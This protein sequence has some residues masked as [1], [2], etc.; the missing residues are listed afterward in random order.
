MAPTLHL[1]APTLA[2]ADD[3]LAF[4]LQNRTFFEASINART[5]GYYSADGM[6]AAITDAID[7]ARADT[8]FQFLVRDDAGTLVARVNLSRVRRAHFHCAEVGYRVAQT[9]SGRGVATQAVGQLVALAFSDL[10]LLRLEAT[11]RPENAASIQVLERNGFER[12]GVARRSFQLHGIW[13]DLI[14]FERHANAESPR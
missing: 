1:T 7:H 5:E 9:A 6:R 8:A 3:L 13:Y 4:E 11:C 10:Q 2:D 12:F 14:C